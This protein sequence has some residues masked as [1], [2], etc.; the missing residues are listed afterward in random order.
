MDAATYAAAHNGSLQNFGG[1][2]HLYPQPVYEERPRD[3]TNS[4][5]NV[6]RQSVS[7]RSLHASGDDLDSRYRRLKFIEVKPRH[8]SNLIK[9]SRL[10]CQPEQRLSS[11]THTVDSVESTATGEETEDPSDTEQALIEKLKSSSITPNS[12]L[13]RR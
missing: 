4:Q 13:P 6:P 12:S 10:G 1:E 9:I 2:M 8:R 7:R 5:Q 3:T 11:R